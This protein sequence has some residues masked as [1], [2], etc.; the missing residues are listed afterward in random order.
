MSVLLVRLPDDFFDLNSKR[1]KMNM[2]PKRR[3]LYQQEFIVAR[4]TQAM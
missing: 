4:A 1:K 2:Q 3:S